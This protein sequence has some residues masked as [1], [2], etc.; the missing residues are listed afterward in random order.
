MTL[1]R[2]GR[3]LKPVVEG[4]GNDRTPDAALIKSIVRAHGWFEQLKTGNV[5]GGAEIVAAEGLMQSYVTR[6]MRLAFYGETISRV[7]NGDFAV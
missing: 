2:R 7:R 4:H 5:S 1:K 3:E 6:I